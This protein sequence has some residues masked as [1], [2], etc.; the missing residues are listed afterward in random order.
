MPL[1]HLGFQAGVDLAAS[2][3]VILRRTPIV[4]QKLCHAGAF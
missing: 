4:R 2:A 1:F 3:R